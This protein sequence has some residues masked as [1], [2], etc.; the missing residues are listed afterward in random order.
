[1]DSNKIDELIRIFED[2]S[3][4]NGE[5]LF[6]LAKATL[7]G[8]QAIKKIFDKYLLDNPNAGTQELRR[9]S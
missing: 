7:K 9:S 5:Y 6:N 8:E 3:L 1:M 4:D 2:L